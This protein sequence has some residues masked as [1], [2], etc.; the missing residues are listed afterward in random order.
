LTYIGQFG[1]KLI[2]LESLII[3]F[4]TTQRVSSSI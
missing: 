1:G 2:G 4:L 3:I